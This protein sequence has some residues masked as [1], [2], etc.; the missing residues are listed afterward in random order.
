MEEEAKRIKKAPYFLGHITGPEQLD[1]KLILGLDSSETIR[2]ALNVEKRGEKIKSP[3]ALKLW[4]VSPVSGEA[5]GEGIDYWGSFKI[6]GR[7][8]VDER[9][10]DGF[11]KELKFLK[12][13]SEGSLGSNSVIESIPYNAFF[14]GEESNEE[15]IGQY[16][17]PFGGTHANNNSLY[18]KQFGRTENSGKKLVEFLQENLRKKEDLY[19]KQKELVF[20]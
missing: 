15:L 2:T 5:K 3:L 20:S 19:K 17:L 9:R 6:Y 16:T 1:K 10:E 4:E 14:A 7:I 11:Q 8:N 13:Y 18:L 12:K